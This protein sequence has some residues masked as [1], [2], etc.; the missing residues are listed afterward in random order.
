MLSNKLILCVAL[1]FSLSVLSAV[2]AGTGSFDVYQSPD[3]DLF[4]SFNLQGVGSAAYNFSTFEENGE[5]HLVVILNEFG[6]GDGR[7]AVYEY[8]WE[9]NNI[10]QRIIYQQNDLQHNGEM[11]WTGISVNTDGTVVAIF[12]NK[13]TDNGVLYEDILGIARANNGEWANGVDIVGRLPLVPPRPGR[14]NDEPNLMPERGT[15]PHITPLFSD[16]LSLLV[17]ILFQ[18]PGEDGRWDHYT[19]RVEVDEADSNEV[20]LEP[21]DPEFTEITSDRPTSYNSTAVRPIVQDLETG[22]V[23]FTVVEDYNGSIRIGTKGDP[24]DEGWESEQIQIDASW[25]SISLSPDNEVWIF[26]QTGIELEEDDES[27]TWIIQ[28]GGEIT[29]YNQVVYDGEHGLY[30]VNQGVWT[31][32]GVLVT[33]VNFWGRYGVEGFQVTSWQQDRDEINVDSTTVLW[34]LFDENGDLNED[35]DYMGGYIAHSHLLAG[36]D[37]GNLYTI[38]YGVEGETDVDGPVLAGVDA[39]DVEAGAEIEIRI[40]DDSG[41]DFESV[42]IHWIMDEDEG[43][44]WESAEPVSMDIDEFGIGIYYFNLP[45]FVTFWINE[46]EFEEI[47][48]EGGENLLIYFDFADLFGN[49]GQSEEFLW[50]VNEL[51]NGLGPEIGRIPE[52]IDFG[53]VPVGESAEFGFTILNTGEASLTG[54]ISVTGDYF[55]AEP[56][57]FEIEPEEEIEVTVTFAPEEEGVFEAELT[58][59]SND[60]YEGEIIVLLTG[61]TDD[62]ED[63]DI[64]DHFTYTENTGENHSFL[65]EGIEFLVDL[66][67]DPGDEIGIF[68]ENDLCVGASHWDED[69]FGVVAWMDDDSTEVIDGFREGE[70]FCFLYYDHDAECELVASHEVIEGDEVFTADGITAVELTISIALAIELNENW[71][72]ISANVD[73]SN[74]ALPILLHPIL[75]SVILMKDGSG[76]F[77]WP[78]RDFWWLNVWVSSRGYK[79]KVTENLELCVTGDPIPDDRPIQLPPRWSMIAY[80]PHQELSARIAFANITEILI[81]A[82]DGWGQFYVPALGFSNMGN[83]TPGHGYQVKLSEE[84]ELVWNTEGE[85][86][87]GDSIFV[88]NPPVEHSV[89]HFDLVSRTCDNMSILVEEVPLSGAGMELGCFN[90]SGLCVGAVSLAGDGPWGLAVWEDDPTTETIDGVVEVEPLF[91]KL[92]DGEKETEVYPV[93]D[94]PVGYI[95]DDFKLLSLSTTPILPVEFGL[96]QPYPNPFNS[97]VLIGFSLDIGADVRIGIFDITGRQVAVLA[98]ESLSAGTHFRVWDASNMAS[99]IYFAR[100][101]AGDRSRIVKMTLIR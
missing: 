88:Y 36:A 44:D 91:F 61:E 87:G 27:Y 65:I 40:D 14:D 71:N 63:E 29:E 58:I 11:T 24:D 19:V 7:N 23:Y 25:P 37:D 20:N 47:P 41:V 62:Y 17:W 68:T 31:S 51:W 18:L 9:G 38:V 67:P 57:E 28:P 100:L 59:T 85:E 6:E 79:T 96:S 80:Y 75:D 98:H 64:E 83:L 95:T 93:D 99:G 78:A 32:D 74:T 54:E 52:T 66:E 3:W 86:D 48:L 46:E 13:Y 8:Y 72:L 12:N 33:G 81:I 76:R 60:P 97:S 22:A 39:E 42:E 84:A 43:F 49:Y 35:N 45:E 89:E 21:Y 53:T 4:N 50:V 30:S 26:G 34:S 92:W 77:A 5:K 55:V 2:Q 70:E 94:S 69:P 56:D 73:P 90:R 10:E 1:F 101:V 15:F 16:T 82:K